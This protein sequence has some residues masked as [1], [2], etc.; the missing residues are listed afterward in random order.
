MFPFTSVVIT[1]MF[2]LSKHEIREDV[3]IVFDTRKF[4]VFDTQKCLYGRRQG[5][6]NLNAGVFVVYD[7]RKIIVFD[8][9]KLVVFDTHNCLYGHRQ[10]ENLEC[11]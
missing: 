9:L 10:R 1:E 3:F 11:R 2:V 5:E 6:K 7:A 8:T 4:V